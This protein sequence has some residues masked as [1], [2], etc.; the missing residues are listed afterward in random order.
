M[1]SEV[2]MRLD[3]VEAQL[4]LCKGGLVATVLLAAVIFSAAVVSSPMKDEKVLRVRGLIIEDAMGRPRIALGAP[5]DQ[6]AGRD[7]TDE[8]VGIVYL[9]ENGADRITFGKS[10]DPMTADGIKPRR[11]GSA[12]IL[13]HDKDG[14]ERGGYSVLDDD[15]AILTLD[16]PKT[17]EAAVMSSG[18]SFSGIAL[19]HKSELGVY[20]EAITFGVESEGD[21]S[22][23]KITD[24]AGVERLSI[25]TSGTDEPALQRKNKSGQDVSGVP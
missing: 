24:S 14:V 19:F 1:R 17:G 12:G 22:F 13:I 6:I 23:A 20:R 4:K 16:W 15:T 8:L 11:V 25:K 7:R 21:K 2:E 9:D 18:D 5:L 3:R 10:P